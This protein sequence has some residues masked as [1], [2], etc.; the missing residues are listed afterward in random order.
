MRKLF[1]GI[2]LI[3][4]LAAL[5]AFWAAPPSSGHV[6]EGQGG[7]SGMG[8]PEGNGNGTWIPEPPGMGDD[9]NG[10]TGNNSTNWA[11][12]SRPNGEN[13]ENQFGQGNGSVNG[14]WAENQNRN[15]NHGDNQSG[16]EQEMEKERVARQD[17]VSQASRQ[18][19]QEMEMFKEEAK[20]N[21]TQNRVRL[22]V[23]ALLGI[24]NLTGIGKNVS[25]I[26]RD[27][28]NSIKAAEGAELN[29][30]KR[31]GIMRTLFGG[32]SSAARELEMEAQQNQQRVQLL[33]QQMDQCQDC[34]NETLSFIQEQ[35]SAMQNETSRLSALA[36]NEK[37]DKGI[38]GWLFGN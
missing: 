36:Q 3:L 24:E 28:N 1:F 32:D 23:H 21:S 37:K 30:S 10:M 18:I 11:N 38:L 25:M 19:Q 7:D 27:F 34:D 8:M 31:S 26:A 14:T 16:M 29:I 35:I 17:Y 13:M 12:G 4:C 20:G 5:P 6:P 33:T 22:A 15:E 9:G 2:V